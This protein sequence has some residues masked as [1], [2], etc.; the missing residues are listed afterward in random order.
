MSTTRR[1]PAILSAD[2]LGYRCLMDVDEVGTLQALK[3]HRREV[4]DPAIAAL[5]TYSQR[6]LQTQQIHCSA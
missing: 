4:I 3:A 1:L 6:S 5:R 2:V